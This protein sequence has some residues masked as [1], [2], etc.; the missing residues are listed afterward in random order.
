MA[1]RKDK[2][3]R[4]SDVVEILKV[5]EDP[6]SLEHTSLA[7][8]EAI[9]RRA[10]E[11]YPGRTCAVGRTLAEELDTCLRQIGED[12][13]ETAVGRLA[14]G[15]A[16]GKTQAAVSRELG[17]SEAYLTRRWKPVLVGLIRCRL[18]A[19]FKEWSASKI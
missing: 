19:D 8:S 2:N 18:E 16:A 11:R 9:R 3:A 6:I 17:I 5:R 15:L 10:L 1:G 14:L 7:S 13:P 12:L 4:N